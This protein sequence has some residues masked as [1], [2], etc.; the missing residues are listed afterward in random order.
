MLSEWL[1]EIPEDFD[2]SWV[3]KMCPVGK[4]NLVV[5]MKVFYIAEN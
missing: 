1:T 5:A 2:V 3:M 4:R